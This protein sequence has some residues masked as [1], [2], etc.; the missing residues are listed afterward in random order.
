M[1][2]PLKES[3]KS[4]KFFRLLVDS[5]RDYAIFMLTPTGEVASWNAGAER[6][7]QYSES[8]IVGQNYSVFYTP[9]DLA[10][11]LPQRNLRIAAEQGHFGDEGWR[12]RKDGT[13]LWCSI[14]I[15]PIQDEEGQLVGFTKITRDI[16]DRKLLMDQIQQHAAD[17][18]HQI[19]ERD[20]MYAEMEAFSYSVSHDLRAPLRAIEG[21]TEA[22]KE[23]LTEA[24]NAEVQEDLA[25][26]TAATERMTLLINDLIE[27]S[28]LG[29]SQMDV[30]LLKVEDLI[31]EV[32]KREVA[33]RSK[34]HTYIAPGLKVMA[35][36][37]AL[38][39]ALVNLVDNALKFHKPGEA[40]EVSI[41][42]SRTD[43]HVRIE[44]HDKGI[45]LAEEHYTRIF[46]VFQRL[47]TTKAYPGTGIGLALV[48]RITERLGGTVG[49][50]S[51]VGKGS[52]FWI[53]I[54]SA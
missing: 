35:H 25:Q 32:L 30:S 38:A 42:A 18:E 40:P 41:S 14:V 4:E 1:T 31:A 45:G 36:K 37:A 11:G 9:E 12:V 48:K 10:R 54:P 34:I 8:E 43:Q 26:I 52:T 47:H 49:V 17:L 16:T 46:Q 27:Y 44:V 33:G 53:E 13:R 24:P 28:R 5:V 50:E 22:L 3:L 7:K 2:A 21:F 39:Q 51:R 20:K 15:T 19:A 29:R 6:I 23:D